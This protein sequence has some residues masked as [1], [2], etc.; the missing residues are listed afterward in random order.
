MDEKFIEMA[1][2]HAENIRAGQQA[3]ISEKAIPSVDLT[4]DQYIRTDCLRC[5]ED[6]IE[7]R[8]KKG[9]VRCTECESKL[10]KH[11]KTT[12]GR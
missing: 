9:L 2:E 6:L 11:L 8:M 10:E 1:E 3:K 4:P 7:F 5:G 12:Y